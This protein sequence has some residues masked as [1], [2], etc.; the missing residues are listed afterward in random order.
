M[1]RTKVTYSIT[2]RGVPLAEPEVTSMNTS[3]DLD[4]PEEGAD[5]ARYL[6]RDLVELRAN[7]NLRI[8]DDLDVVEVDLETAAGKRYR[9][10]VRLG[11]E[12]TFYPMEVA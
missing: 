6:A 10:Q 12:R 5:G 11:W 2:A 7:D 1:I 8:D 4:D 9:V 3:W